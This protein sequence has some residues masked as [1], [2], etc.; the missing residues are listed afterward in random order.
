MTNAIFP[1]SSSF[2]SASAGTGKTKTLID[3]LLNLLL[4]QT[5]PNKILCLTFT[6]AAA[7]E[8]LSRINQKLAYF[9]TCNR[10]ILLEELTN[11][12]HSNITPELEHRAR[13]LF[14]ELLDEIDPL[15][16]Q[17]IHAFCQ[18]LLLKFPLEAGVNLNFSLLNDNQMSNLIDQSKTKLLDSIDQYPNANKSLSYLSWH[19]KEYNLKELLKEIIFN[20]GKL[21]T[22]FEAHQT[23]ENALNSLNIDVP[24]EETSIL[25]FINNTPISIEQLSPLYGG[26]KSDINRAN[27]LQTF[28][29]SSIQ[30]K[31]ISLSS[32]IYCFL[33]KSDEPLK[34]LMTKKITEQYPEL[35]SLLEREQ[36]RVYKF[37]KLFKHIKAI[38]LTK[39]FITLSFYIREIYQNLKQQTGSLDYDDLISLCYKLLDNSEYAD[40]I[41]YKLDGGI[42]HILI[43]EAQDTS[44]IQWKIINK[45]SE[46]FFY[47]TESHKSMFIVGDAKQS[48][49]SFQGAELE[50][51]NQMNHSLPEEVLRIQLNRSFRSGQKI[52]QL[53]D[54]IF[55]QD[56][57]KPL[58]SGIEKEI[59]HIAH[60]DIDS[61]VEL[62]PLILEPESEEV[63]PWVLPNDF[64]HNKNESADEKLAQ[65]IKDNIQEWIKNG[66]NPGD[67]MILTRRRTGFVNHIIKELRQAHIPVTGLDR[68]KLLEHPA[69]LDLIALTHFVLCP[70]DDMNLAIILKSPI[71]NISEE[72][73]FKLCANRQDSLWE[74]L[75]DKTLLEELIE[76]SKHKTPFE[77]F[78]YILEYKHLRQ[79]FIEHLTLE[80]N[81]ILDAFLDLV[82]QFEAEN[83]PS[84][85]LFLDFLSSNK[86]EVKRDL[87]QTN[88]QV[89]IMTIHGAKGLQAKIIILA[90]STSLPH[91]DDSIIWL[92]E[93]QLLWPG[94]AKYYPDIAIKAKIDK[95]DKEYAEYLR[96]LYVA[97]TRAEEKLIIC[98]TA[99]KESIS[100][101]CWYS[102][103]KNSIQSS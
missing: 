78:F 34:S 45:L 36:H 59:K 17:T 55:N 81:D 82:N 101:K 46:D 6:K 28:I 57:I 49:F 39:A 87:S 56:H 69:I 48:I 11:L 85:Q 14:T 89:R 68:L 4:H 88:N 83:I 44:A 27:K 72:D 26:G 5:K 98:G 94:K 61:S 84:L 62:W 67:I 75:E 53:V 43:D 91:N 52:L 22:F 64:I 24:D 71:Y 1:E 2:V 74:S 41:R 100:E 32:Y 40:W 37:N 15:N 23:L 35:A 73:L 47:Q 30:L 3:R 70:A 18:Q 79:K 51:F 95:L 54:N 58:V 8:I 80:V 77:F 76:L 90:D 33:T 92:N 38:N 21:D 102:I 93:D 103:V 96:L 10:D 29:T 99:K 60:K 16:I 50:L 12:G 97:L 66:I 20:R 31:N 25:D 63:Q 42:D 9:S 86:T 19:I 7:A 13:I 65:Q